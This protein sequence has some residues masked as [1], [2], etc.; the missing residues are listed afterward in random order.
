MF[1]RLA[2]SKEIPVPPH[3]SLDYIYGD[4]VKY[5][6]SV[7]ENVTN[8]LPAP[9]DLT[10]TLSN[11]GNSDWSEVISW[12]YEDEKVNEFEFEVC[13]KQSNDQWL[14]FV[15]GNTSSTT[16]TI[17]LACD[18]L[19]EET[20]LRIRALSKDISQV[21]SSE[22][23]EVELSTLPITLTENLFS[24]NTDNVEYDGSAKTKEIIPAVIPNHQLVQDT[25]YTVAYANNTEIGTATIT[26]TGI[27]KYTGELT[28]S[29]A[30][31]EAP[32]G[33]GSVE[34]G[35]VPGG[36]TYDDLYTPSTPS[37]VTQSTTNADGSVT[38]TTTR[39][40][41][42]T[43][44]TTT[45]A[46]GVVGTVERSSSGEITS[47]QV[48][49]SERAD[50]GI[51]TAPVEVAPS[52]DS[53]SAPEIS[54]KTP[55]GSSAKVEIPVTNAGPGT[56]AV[57]VNPDGTEEVIRDCVGGKNG[58]IFS[59]EGDITVKIVERGSAFTDVTGASAWAS[60]AVEFV[61]A[62][63]LFNGTGSNHFTPAGNMSRGMMVTVLYRLAYEP[64][65]TGAAFGDVGDDQFYSEAVAWAADRNVA[66]GY[67]ASTFGPDDDVTREQMVTMLYRYAKS[68]GWD[69]TTAQSALSG[70]A[71]AN[72]VHDFAKDAMAWAVEAG[73]ILG[74]GD[75]NLSPE[76]HATRAEAATIMMRFCKNVIFGTAAAKNA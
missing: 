35:D 2:A 16:Y 7:P 51:V 32:S 65:S 38:Q 23:T 46:D 37:D 26:I 20:K 40:D 42:T 69:V 21:L 68:S 27:G 4:Y 66:N 60:D 63:E 30:I 59:T 61:A 29:F 74:N 58:V 25:D 57:K 6:I 62:R 24:V 41:G 72:A 3:I 53:E 67:N 19:W 10:R 76:G 5:V 31:T 44:E 22:W 18:R 55:A 56:V 70:F 45:T 71:D 36:D 52:A 43:T 64:K 1:I 47:A 15:T 9:E 75:G 54:V 8:K 12:P 17:Y 49:I 39:V 34:G 50:G 73:I 13:F 14:P 28:Y 11:T 48:T 33:G